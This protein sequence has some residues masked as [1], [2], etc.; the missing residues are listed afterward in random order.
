[1]ELAVA[2]VRIESSPCDVTSAAELETLLDKCSSTWPPI[3]GCINAIML[4]QVPSDPRTA[5]RLCRVA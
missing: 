2:G 3:K 1:M 5:K 4:L